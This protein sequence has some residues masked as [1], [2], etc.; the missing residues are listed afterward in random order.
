[1][2]EH[3]SEEIDLGQLFQLIGNVINSFFKFIRDIFNN[4]FH[5]SILFLKFIRTHFLKFIIV[6]FLGVMLGGY[7]DYKSQP[8]YKSSMIIEPNFN[9]VQQLYNNIEFYNQ[10]AKQQENKALAEALHI[11]E[12]EALYIKKVMIE[13]FSDETQRIKQFS[14]FIGELDSISQKQV[15]YEYYLKNFNDI[16]AKFHKIQIEATSPEI[17]KKCQNTIVNSIENNEYFKLQKEINDYNIAL[18]DS[19][20]EQQQKEI[21]DLQEFYKKV[22]ILEAKKPDG[23][24]SINL[25]E[26]KPYQTSE[27]ELLNQAQKLKDEKIE[28]NNEKGNTKNTINII[29]EFPNKGALVNDF[30]NKKIVLMPIIFVTI[31]FLILIL[32][33]L[34]IYLMNYDKLSA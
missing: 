20:I 5:L 11:P 23:R 18:E 3:T 16:N 10:L 19:I 30:L 28:L 8:I 15:D 2:R 29:S 9:S 24:T 34:N 22:K 6:V 26:N 7:L 33:S 31:L 14:E 12:K 21:D 1:M 13:S 27:I 32:I 25:A 4:I 17:A